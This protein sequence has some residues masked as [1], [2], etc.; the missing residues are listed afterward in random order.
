MTAIDAIA[1]S[2]LKLAH[3]AQLALDGVD[4]TLRPG[5]IVGLIGP[6]GAGKST[7]LRI[8]AG[9][10]PPD[11]GQ[12]AWGGQTAGEIGRQQLARCVAW[13]SQSADSLSDDNGAMRASDIVALGRL[14]H[15]RAFASLTAADHAAIDRAMDEADCRQFRDRPLNGL[16]GGERVRVLLARALA[17]EAPF[18]LADEPAAA[19]D[20]LHQLQVMRLLRAKARAGCGVLVTLHDLALA[21]RFCDRL[22][23]LVDGRKLA[24]GPPQAVLDDAIVARAF[25][26]RLAHASHR[27]ENYVTPWEPVDPWASNRTEDGHD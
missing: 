5:E 18:L 26:V 27:G 1:A 25:H 10:A 14:P 15:R 6:N 16:S 3:G 21:S 19:L 2:G 8:L 22:A 7:L 9:V 24:D 17:V 12:I 23:L 4:F 13:L 11:A 20:P